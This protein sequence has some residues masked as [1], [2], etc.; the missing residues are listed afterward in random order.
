MSS[1]RLLLD[2][3]E[4]SSLILIM[5]ISA[6][7]IVALFRESSSV[8]SPTMEFLMTCM[9]FKQQWKVRWDQYLTRS[10]NSLYRDT[11]QLI[12]LVLLDQEMELERNIIFKTKVQF[13]QAWK[14]NEKYIISW[15]TRNGSTFAK[16]FSGDSMHQNT[17][18]KRDSKSPLPQALMSCQQ[19]CQL[20][21]EKGGH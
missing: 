14:R 20:K 11:I 13:K 3:L 10:I 4:Y 21:E 19:K 18:I 7:L 2:T 6:R 1:T 16:Y 15:C 8:P 12:W 17:A 9:W 5:S